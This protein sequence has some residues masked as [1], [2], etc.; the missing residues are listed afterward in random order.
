VPRAET[1]ALVAQLTLDDKGF[2]RGVDKAIRKSGQLDKT[3]SNVGSKAGKGLSTA[4]GNIAKITTIASIG[5]VGLLAKSVENASSLNEQINKTKAVFGDASK[6][7]LAFSQT[8]ADKLGLS[9]IEALT[10]AGAFGNMF[11]TTGLAEAKAADMSKTLVTLA[12]DMASFNDEDPSEMLDRLRSGLSGEAE[13][14]R[15]FGVLLSEARVKEEAYASGIAKRGDALTEAQKVQA[16]YALILKDTAVQQG[17][18]EKTAGGM[19][20]LMRRLKGNLTDA[21]TVIG[22]ALL[23]QIVNLAK[24]LNDLVVKNGP[25]IQEFANKLPGAFDKALAFA[26]KIPWGAIAAGLES[27]AHWAGV[28][29]DAFLGLPPEVQTTI[30]ALAGLNKLSGGAISGIA[31]ELGKG[32]IKGVLGI[33][34]GVVNVRAATVAGVGGGVA[35]GAAA[36]GATSTAGKIASAAS[37]VFIIGAAAAFIAELGSIRGQQSEENKQ[38][39]ADLAKQTK[40]FA[41]GASLADLKQSLKG[42]EERESQ[43]RSGFAPDQI[44][45]QLDIDGIA[46]AME[47]SQQTLRDKITELEASGKTNSA[48]ENT[49]QN[50]TNERLEAIETQ[51][52]NIDAVAGAVRNSS[53]QN[54]AIATRNQAAAFAIRD[55]VGTS[56]SLVI[57][58]VNAVKTVAAATTSATQTVASRQNIANER[59]EAIRRKDFSPTVNISAKFSIQELSKGQKTFTKTFHSTLS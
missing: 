10:A 15:R 9:R 19:A 44:A 50:I 20:N 40:D 6:S 58:A 17:D 41:G 28:L 34:A 42:L 54:A 13:P 27:A 47:Q 2:N 29:F 49:A 21:S 16:R 55:R 5:A 38:G 45:F 18:F 48:A 1:A 57:G 8:T 31:S 14:L 32:L 37:K 22:A 25:A 12:A 43:L 4:A 7:V 36:G 11:K 59:L 3:L 33:N 24:K 56:G 39:I 30:I 53:V 26:E 51:K 23:P 35:G 52:A 46:T